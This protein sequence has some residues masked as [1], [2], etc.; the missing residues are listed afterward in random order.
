MLPRGSGEMGIGTLLLPATWTHGQQ[1]GVS[2]LVTDRSD[3]VSLSPSRLAH[4]GNRNQEGKIEE[5]DDR[6]AK[7]CLTRM[8][9]NLVCTCQQPFHSFYL[10]GTYNCYL[11]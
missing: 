8:F 6:W 11:C 3:V 1:H 4:A 7:L 2:P 5:I 9:L 10:W